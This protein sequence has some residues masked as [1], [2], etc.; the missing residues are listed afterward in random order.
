MRLKT[1]LSALAHWCPLT[2]HVSFFTDFVANLSQIIIENIL[3]FELSMSFFVHWQ[4]CWF[5]G[6]PAEPIPIV[7][8]ILSILHLEASD[9]VNYLDN[10]SYHPRDYVWPLL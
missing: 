7:E 9:L 10:Q 6:Y 8:G 5:E 2:A 3:L 1:V 4:Q